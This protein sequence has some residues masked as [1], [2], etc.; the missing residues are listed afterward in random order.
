MP[1][2]ITIALGLLVGFIGLVGLAFFIYALREGIREREYQ[3]GTVGS[4]VFA[5]GCRCQESEEGYVLCA[6]PDL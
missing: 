6:H 1:L 5:H 4:Q 2:G 3:E